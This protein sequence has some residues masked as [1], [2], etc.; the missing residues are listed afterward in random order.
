MP[1]YLLNLKTMLV[2]LKHELMETGFMVMKGLMVEPKRK[3]G[4]QKQS[5][6]S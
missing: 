4:L 5:L 2:Q 3:M 1:L 6:N